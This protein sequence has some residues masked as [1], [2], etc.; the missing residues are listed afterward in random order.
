MDIVVLTQL[1]K[2]QELAKDTLD[3]M[4]PVER[5]RQ[6][7]FMTYVDTDSEVGVYKVGIRHSSSVA[8]EAVMKPFTDDWDDV[9]AVTTEELYHLF[10]RHKST[11]FQEVMKRY[12]GTSSDMDTF[13]QGHQQEYMTRKRQE[14]LFYGYFDFRAD[15]LKYNRGKLR[16]RRGEGGSSVS[17]GSDAYLMMEGIQAKFRMTAPR[18]LYSKVAELS[19]LRRKEIGDPLQDESS[20]SE[21]DGW[22]DSVIDFSQC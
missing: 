7:S 4:D 15:A 5:W 3:R 19:R 17:W 21:D 12:T 13:L 1:L 18:E 11:L 8:L 6:D 2:D 22:D 20:A 10:G 14:Q 9:R 16:S